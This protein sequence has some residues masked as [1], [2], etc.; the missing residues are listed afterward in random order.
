MSKT[1]TWKQLAVAV[2]SAGALMLAAPV[3]AV[4]QSE[5]VP[6]FSYFIDFHESYGVED[7]VIQSL[8]QELEAGNLPASMSGEDPDKIELFE[9]VLSIE[10]L[11]TYSDGSISVTILET[12]SET[13]SSGG[14]SPQAISGCTDNSGGG[15]TS[16]SNCHISH[17]TGIINMWFTAN[18]TFWGSG[19]SITS[20][21]NPQVIAYYGTATLPTLNRSSANTS[22]S[23][24]AVVTSHS[25]YTS[26]AGTSSED[27]YLSLRVF[28]TYAT[29]TTY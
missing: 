25:R 11:A 27:L 2:L 7:S 29:T 15:Y 17:G 28:G 16:K 1:R 12:E 26:W 8:V 19:G 23:N 24:P 5:S 20:A 6:D 9:T 18:Y 21:H 4:A 14:I 10:S 22:G 13:G 3:S